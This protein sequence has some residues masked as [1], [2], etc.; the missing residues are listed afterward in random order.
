MPVGTTMWS[1]VA[2]NQP[3][4]GL[5]LGIGIGFGLGVGLEEV[6]GRVR[7]EDRSG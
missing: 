1:S 4:L 7:V 6:R 2:Y 3:A 5:G